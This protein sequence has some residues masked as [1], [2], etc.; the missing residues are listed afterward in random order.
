MRVTILS[1]GR[2]LG[3]RWGLG[4]SRFPAAAAVIALHAEAVIVSSHSGT[5]CTSNGVDGIDSSMK[6]DVCVALDVMGGDHGPEI[7]V[8]AAAIA[9]ERRPDLAFVLYGDE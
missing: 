2:R 5:K 7:V 8:P 3:L 6:K 4:T 1:R 9:L